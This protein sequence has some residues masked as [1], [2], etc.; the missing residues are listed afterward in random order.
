M[1]GRLRSSFEHCLCVRQNI[2]HDRALRP[3]RLAFFVASRAHLLIAVEQLDV[4]AAAQ[5]APVH[6]FRRH[7]GRAG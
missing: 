4:Q 3:V 7:S 5:F 6:R 2:A 1:C